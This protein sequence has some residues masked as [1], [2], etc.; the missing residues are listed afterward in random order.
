MTTSIPEAPGSGR[1]WDY[2]Y[3]WLRD[4]YFVVNELNRLGVTGTMERY[5][6]YILNV[7]ADAP[8]MAACS[9]CTASAEARPSM[10]EQVDSLPGY[11]GMGPVRAGNQANR[12]VQHDVYGS[13]I[14]AATHVFFD[15]RLVHVETTR[16]SV[17]SRRSVNT[18]RALRQPDAG[19]W[20][21]AA[22][23]GAHVL[24]RD[25]LGR[26]RQTRQN[27]GAPRTCRTGTAY[28]RGQA[29]AHPSRAL[30]AA[31]NAKLGSFCVDDG[32]R[33]LDASLLLLERS[34]LPGR[35]RPAVRGHG[36]RRRARAA[37]RRLRVPLSREGRLR[38]AG[39][40]VSG[41]HF[42]V[43]QRAGR[44]RPTG[45]GARPLRERARLPQPARPAGRAHR[46][47]HQEQWGNFV[48]TYSMVGLIGSAIRLS[49][50][51]DQA[52]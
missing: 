43:H 40:R 48:Q 33:T 1:N 31:W 27:R 29:D 10:S 46:P 49:V 16:C 13:A 34:G 24:Q 7:V 26:M 51:W 37:S 19:I 3:C 28:W 21:C 30:R 35:G 14:L 12:Q 44:A 18:P 25:V 41:L 5:L 32:G 52:F 23:T 4:A 9:R 2:R 47:A 39:E 50:R 17:A 38:P 45:R 20:E 15:R 11:R 8:K 6:E 36:A 22:P 42:L